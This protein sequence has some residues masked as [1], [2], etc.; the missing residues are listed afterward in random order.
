MITLN[1]GAVVGYPLSALPCR[2]WSGRQPMTCAGSRS[3]MVDMGCMSPV[4]MRIFPCLP[5]WPTNLAK[6]S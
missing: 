2:A 1:T 4:W 5:F 6:P 3:K